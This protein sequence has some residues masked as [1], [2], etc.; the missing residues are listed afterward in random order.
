MAKEVISI[1]ENAI[2]RPVSELQEPEWNCRIHTERGINALCSSMR[3]AGFVDPVIVWT[4]GLI[5]S[6]SA[7]WKAAKKLKM[8]YVPIVDMSNLSE[9]QAK[10]YSLA[11]NRVPE[12]NGFDEEK[13]LLLSMEIDNVA[14]ETLFTSDE[15]EEKRKWLE[16]FEID[17]PEIVDPDPNMDEDT[18]VDGILPKVKRLGQ[19][20]VMISVPAGMWLSIQEEVVSLVKGLKKRHNEISYHV[21]EAAE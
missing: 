3:L 6:G 10:F 13:R 21:R 5:L 4:D 14:R 19:V 9:E 11:A 15:I 7:R 18:N 17:A 1:P 20:E 12:F 8:E 2:L 16:D